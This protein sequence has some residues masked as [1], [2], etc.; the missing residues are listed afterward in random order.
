MRQNA[1]GSDLINSGSLRAKQ[2]WRQT[3]HID[4]ESFLHDSQIHLSCIKRQVTVQQRIMIP[5][6]VVMLPSLLTAEDLRERV[7]VVF[8]VLRAT[9]TM[10]AA[11]QAGAREIR[12]F[13]SLDQA[14]K[15]WEVFEGPKLL[16]GEKNCLA[17]SGFDVGNSPVDFTR[18]RCQDRTIFMSTSNGTRALVAA[19]QASKLLAGAIVNA[20]ATA[21]AVLSFQQPITLLCAGTGG[22]IALEDL[23]GAGTVIEEIGVSNLLLENDEAYIAFQLS[24]SDPTGDRLYICQGGKNILQARLDQDICYA[25]QRNAIPL[26]IRV[27]DVCGQLIASAQYFSEV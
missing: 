16:A 12:V 25:G 2:R 3:H 1:R 4:H 21:R 6:R 13:D 23:Q 17:P 26:T 19:R 14:K 15:A 7:V 27:S 24:Q 18:V 20:S 11:L 8:D 5:L 9:T 10:A 22:K